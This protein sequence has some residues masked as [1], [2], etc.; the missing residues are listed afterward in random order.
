ML[1]ERGDYRHSP[2]YLKFILLRQ[3]AGLLK[4]FAMRRWTLISLATALITTP[5]HADGVILPFIVAE[6]WLVLTLIPGV[7]LEAVVFFY[8]LKGLGFSSA[9]WVSLWMNLVST[10]LGSLFLIVLLLPLPAHWASFAGLLA[11]TFI[12]TV[13]VERAVARRMLHE[14]ASGS[15]T[16]AVIAGNVLTY[17]LISSVYFFPPGNGP[18]ACEAIDRLGSLLNPVSECIRLSGGIEECSAGAHGMPPLP[19]PSSLPYV[20]TISLQKGVL[21]AE[22]T[23]RDGNG[24]PLVYRA[25]FVR[26]GEGGWMRDESGSAV[27]ACRDRLAFQW[28]IWTPF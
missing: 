17:V 24:K 28:G 6:P 27:S 1:L 25:T 16:R 8:F 13:L 18:R 11:A 5:A 9:L 23:F 20:Q 26:F 7:L 2:K 14:R 21:L 22:L 12:F 15:V 19:P 10:L 3:D 4:R